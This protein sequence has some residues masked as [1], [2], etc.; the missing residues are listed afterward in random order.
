M[1]IGIITFEFNYN[2]GAI[3]QA[4]ALLDYLRGIGHSPLI[5]NRGWKDDDEGGGEI[6]SVK[7]LDD[8]GAI[9]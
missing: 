2:Y 1:K 8:Y 7:L 4:T 5:I 3:L 6:L 9:N